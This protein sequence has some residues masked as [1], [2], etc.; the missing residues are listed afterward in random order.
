MERGR[1]LHSAESARLI[2][3]MRTHLLYAISPEMEAVTEGIERM[4]AGEGFRPLKLGARTT[5]GLMR[6]GDCE[7]F[8]KRRLAG[9]WLKGL[10]D[11]V[12]GSRAARAIRGASMLKAAG[13]S[14]PKPLVAFETRTLGAVRASYIV[15]ESL[16]DARILSRFALTG[17]RN[18]RRRKWISRR[19]ARELH[20]LH[21]AGL[22]SG[23]MQETNLMLAA[24]GDEIMIYFVD[25]EDLR[26]ASRVS[27]RRRMRNLVHLDRSIGR[28]VP[29]SQRLR[30]LYNYLGGKPAGDEARRLVRRLIALGARIEPQI[31]RVSRIALSQ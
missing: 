27:E 22:Y 10:Y 2:A 5:A 4:M 17:G 7:V 18:F 31:V 11:R 24:E 8:V 1:M 25:L 3:R 26:R 20:R 23:D 15:C 16:R 12:R 21:E 29:R 6:L 30:F 19:L 9:P 14:C 28:F 13:F